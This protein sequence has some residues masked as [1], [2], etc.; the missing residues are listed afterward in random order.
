M[1][2][3][4]SIGY[5]SRESEVKADLTSMSLACYNCK[6]L[7]TP[8][9][10]YCG[11][12]SVPV[13]LRGVYYVRRV[14]DTGGF[15]TV[16]DVVDLHANRRYA[17]KEVR[18]QATEEVRLMLMI[19]ERLS[20]VPQISNWWH[21]HGRTYILMEFV[22]GQALWTLP[23]PWNAA[24]VERFT[25][26]MLRHLYQLHSLSIVHCDINPKNIKR[27]GPDQ[28]RLLD[29]GIALD[30]QSGSAIPTGRTNYSPIEQYRGLPVDE[31][32]DLYSLAAVAFHF[33]TGS[34]PPVAPLRLAGEALPAL[35][36]AVAA[37]LSPGFEQMLVAM[38]SLDANDRPISAKAA[39][40]LFQQF[41]APGRRVFARA[42]SQTKRLREPEPPRVTIP[43]SNSQAAAAGTLPPSPPQASF[44][45]SQQPVQGRRRRRIA[46]G[47]ASLVA[48]IVIILVLWPFNSGITGQLIIISSR[49]GTEEIYTL[50]PN[51]TD[52][53]RLTRNRV[54]ERAPHWSPRGDKIAFVEEHE[55]QSNIIV[56]SS[57]A[58]D[59]TK[60]TNVLPVVDHEKNL[61][62]DGNNWWPAWSPDGRLIAF[63]T[64][65]DGDVEIYRVLADGAVSSRL[66]ERPGTDSWPAWSPDGRWIV[67]VH[68]DDDGTSELF[69]IPAIGGEP[70]QL[71]ETFTAK[72][73]PAWAPS[74]KSIAFTASDG[75]QSDLYLL[76]LASL[77]VRQLTSTAANEFDPTWSPDSEAI[78]FVSDDD[79]DN[80]IYILHME[81]DRVVQI[82]SNTANDEF[83]DWSR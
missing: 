49:D 77:E 9:P 18:S 13:L 55:G 57:D 76:D 8:P 48:L 15:G 50:H 75:S 39:L 52:I 81:D 54:S 70:E 25:V 79:G 73:D 64:N 21:D 47:G 7:T 68:I 24:E 43:V 3:A 58:K 29:F 36:A 80:D 63:A 59:R 41:Q 40:R 51:G 30:Q 46:L 60:L 83:P 12:C 56:I 32:A 35:D 5:A 38:L 26:V 19:S 10:A 28:Y 23:Q 4:R 11:R 67:F 2:G 66:T 74:G 78:A 34:A 72:S 1:S 6:K 17:L 69:K 16:Y 65:R 44:P 45:M 33:L 71:T 14:V 62:K 42:S 20:F 82:T 27:V 53:R 37:S 22:D 61:P 31:R